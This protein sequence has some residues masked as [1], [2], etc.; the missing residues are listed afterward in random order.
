[1]LL[2]DKPRVVFGKSMIDKVSCDRFITF[3][4]SKFKKS[5]TFHTDKNTQLS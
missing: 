3:G 5:E 4:N 1:M 2:Y